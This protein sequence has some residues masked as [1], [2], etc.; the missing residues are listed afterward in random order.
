[1][2]IATGLGPYSG[3]AV[4]FKTSGRPRRPKDSIRRHNRYQLLS[5]PPL[6]DPRRFIWPR[7]NTWSATPTTIVDMAFWGWA[8]LAPFVRRR[9]RLREIP[10]T[11]NCWSTKC[12]AGCPGCNRARSAL[13][14]V[15]LETEWTGGEHIMFGSLKTNAA[16][17]VRHTDRKRRL[18]GAFCFNCVINCARRPAS[19]SNQ[20]ARRASRLTPTRA[21]GPFPCSIAVPY[22][23]HFRQVVW[24]PHRRGAVQLYDVGHGGAGR[25]HRKLDVSEYP[26]RRAPRHPRAGP[27]AP[28]AALAPG[29]AI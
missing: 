18:T 20:P 3:H 21:A 2:F 13:K 22:R 8:R 1:M 12:P 23:P 9:R 19:I 16:D 14:A 17:R 6:Q 26:A 4:H 10:P 29:P 15:H 11:S 25:L 28:E 7:A 5:P 24:L 27:A